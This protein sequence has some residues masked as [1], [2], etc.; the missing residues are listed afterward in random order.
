ML[1]YYSKKIREGDSMR[2]N[3]KKDYS[4]YFLLIVSILL[5][6]INFGCSFRFLGDIEIVEKVGIIN[7]EVMENSEGQEQV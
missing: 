4:L 2:E 3:V 6:F 5:M 7:A 1:Y